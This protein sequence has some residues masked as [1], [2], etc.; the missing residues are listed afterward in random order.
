M[1]KS[2]TSR[3][4]TRH[5]VKSVHVT[6]IVIEMP[7]KSV[8][9]VSKSPVT[10]VPPPTTGPELREV[11][12]PM[13]DKELGKEFPAQT[14]VNMKDL[15]RSEKTDNESLCRSRRPRQRSTNSNYHNGVELGLED[16]GLPLARKSSG[17]NGDSYR[18][19]EQVLDH[20][21]NG[22]MDDKTAKVEETIYR[23]RWSSRPSTM[24]TW[25]PNRHLPRCQVVKYCDK[26]NV[27]YPSDILNVFVRR[28]EKSEMKSDPS[29]KPPSNTSYEGN[30]RNREE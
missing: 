11:K 22:N 24:D 18:T 26:R 3:R 20:N 9:H 23:I 21:I 14:D 4:R 7:D 6:K 25:E 1:S 28:L 17:T 29:Y 30:K 13:T 8:E 12:I 19:V 10:L 2:S 27:S 5:S 15:L 16:Q